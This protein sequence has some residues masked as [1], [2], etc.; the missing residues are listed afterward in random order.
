MDNQFIEKLK[1]VFELFTG[2]DYLRPVMK[3]PFKRDGY[4]FATD[5]HSLV[6]MRDTIDL[7]YAE[8][9]K[10]PNCLAVIPSERHEPILIDIFELEEE[11]LGRTPIVD[12][13]ID[14]YDCDGEGS[15]ECNLGHSHNC[16]RCNGTGTVIAKN[17]KKVLDPTTLYLLLGQCFLYPRLIKLIK[18]CKI[19]DCKTVNKVASTAKNRSAIFEDVNVTYLIMPNFDDQDE[20]YSKK[21][22]VLRTGTVQNN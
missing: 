6:Y 14:C 20:E 8:N 4:Y 2:N 19:L 12:E 11:I 1:Q 9:L 3:T 7:G 5:A 15:E 22:I 10:A 17:P 16:N 18:A 21:P 13:T